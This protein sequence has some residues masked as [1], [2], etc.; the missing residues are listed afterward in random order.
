MPP[1]DGG[2]GSPPA[3]KIEERP[4]RRTA[5]V[6]EYELDGD[7]ILVPPRAADGVVLNATAARMWALCDGTH[8][9][10]AVARRIAH[11]YAIDE[12]RA[13]ADVQ[14]FAAALQAA[15]LLANPAAAP[16]PAPRR[17]E[18][19]IER[20]ARRFLALTTREDAE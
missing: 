8:P 11:D 1:I 12:Q 14:A 5:G 20:K 10:V 17:A 16:R 3:A 18:D 9:P 6:A 2:S 19:V 13:L 4:L 7:L 15:N